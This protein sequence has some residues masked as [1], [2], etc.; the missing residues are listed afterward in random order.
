MHSK[1]ASQRLPD[2]QLNAALALMQ[3]KCKRWNPT[4]ILDMLPQCMSQL[5]SYYC[6]NWHQNCAVRLVLQSS[7]KLL[8]Q[9]DENERPSFPFS[10]VI[11]DVA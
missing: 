10:C 5:L 6:T 2:C 7:P 4:L 9:F 8:P 1:K 11:T 3:R